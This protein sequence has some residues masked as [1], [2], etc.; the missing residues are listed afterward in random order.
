M[1]RLSFLRKP[2][3]PLLH[4]LLLALILGAAL[5]FG[6]QAVLDALAL[7]YAMDTYAYV[8]NVVLHGRTASKTEPLPEELM[9]RLRECELVE[10][11]EI[12]Q[13]QAAMLEGHS[14]VPDFMMS[15]NRLNQNYFAEITIVGDHTQM[16]QTGPF[17][18]G[19]YSARLDR[20]WGA[21]TIG[22]PSLMLTYIHTPDQPHLKKGTRLFLIANYVQEYTGVRTNYLFLAT[23][24][25]RQAMMGQMGSLLESPLRQHPFVEIPGEL[26][27]T[28][29]ET[30]IRN[31]MEETGVAPLYQRY[32]QLNTAMTVRRVSD[33]S[34]LPY[35]SKGR[36]YIANG[37]TLYERDAGQKVCLISQNLSLR[38]R[39]RVGDTVTLRLAE[40]CYTIDQADPGGGWESGLPMDQQ[41]LLSY[42]QPEEYTIVGIYHQLGREAQDPQFFGHNDIFLPG[43]ETVTG[44]VARPYN[45]SFRVSGPNQE[46]FA[47]EFGSWPEAEGYDLKLVDN[48]WQEA[49][50]SFYAMLDR[51]TLMTVCALLAFGAAAVT[52]GLLTWQHHRYEYGLRR[53]LGAYGRE[54]AGIYRWGFP[55]PALPGAALSLAGAWGV[56]VLWLKEALYNAAPL[57]MPADWEILVMLGLWVLGTLGISRGLVALLTRLRD[58][59][60][61]LR[62]MEEGK[63]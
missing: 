1:N 9:A 20:Q 24:E 29:T 48:G 41:E 18:Y 53:L 2:I 62:L 34:L 58:T 33:L 50:D 49:R 14:T 25:G 15:S 17:V 45:L 35:V 10:S 28:E 6:L 54:A 38:N 3:R 22:N 39:L 59:R 31:W 12:R 63:A 47:A 42:G 11:L 5:V 30:F 57:K 16:G 51:K 37:R 13:T 46:A 43:D 26:D 52:Y 21:N 32:T 4:G 8:G 60:S 40:G 19:S 44:T 27:E 61:I 7:E 36:I 23:P 56:Y 55:I